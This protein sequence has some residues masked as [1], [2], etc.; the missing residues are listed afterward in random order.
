MLYTP[1]YGK[2]RDVH[3]K[4]VYEAKEKLIAGK[5]SL[6]ERERPNKNDLPHRL[7][8]HPEQLASYTPESLK[9]KFEE[10]GYETKPLSKGA[11]RGLLF[12]DGGGYKVNFDGD[13]I[14]QYH[15][16]KFSHHNGA[17]YKIGNGRKGINRYDL[18]GKEQ[19]D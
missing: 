19:E 17:Y 2:Y 1:G 6:H 12:E 14:I 5:D 4:K 16:E 18:S 8:D 3:S 7:L 13:G 10:R 15:P 9:G 11:L